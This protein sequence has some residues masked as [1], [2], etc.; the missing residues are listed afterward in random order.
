MRT[1]RNGRY[2]GIL[3]ALAAGDSA[4]RVVHA[5]AASH[6]GTGEN[7]VRRLELEF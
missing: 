4:A 7:A 2:G 6:W 3:A 1:L 5:V